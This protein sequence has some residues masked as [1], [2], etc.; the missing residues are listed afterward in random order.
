MPELSFRYVNPATAEAERD[1]L[2]LEQDSWSAYTGLLTKAGL[3]RY[4]RAALYGAESNAVIDCGFSGDS[5]TIVIH[6]WPLV[7]GVSFRLRTSVGELGEVLIDTVSSAESVSFTLT[8]R[9]SLRH[10]AD[11]IESV[12]W[13]VGPYDRAGTLIA[14]PALSV[15][16]RE[17]TLSAPVWGCAW[18]RSAGTRYACAVSI[19]RDIAEPLLAAGWSEYV[20]G[21]PEGGRPVA[22]ELSPPPGAEALA[23]SG[24]E[25]GRGSRFSVR[26]RDGASPPEAQ[27][28]DKTVKCD[29]CALRCEDEDSHA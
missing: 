18:I 7:P 23:R 3:A 21:L 8:D 19:P 16:G 1:L 11:V 14:A 25:C 4:L 15:S 5:L 27:P 29:Y 24:G 26:G 28:R 10:P 13:L 12:S 2:L 9:A 17:L 22:L 20:I 6:A